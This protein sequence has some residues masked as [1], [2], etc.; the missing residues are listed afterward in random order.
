MISNPSYELALFHS[1]S[2][3]QREFCKL[4]WPFQKAWSISCFWKKTQN[5]SD[6]PYFC[7]CGSSPRS[8]SKIEC[9][10]STFIRFLFSQMCP[11][12]GQDILPVV[13]THEAE[14]HLGM[15]HSWIVEDRTIKYNPSQGFPSLGAQVAASLT[16]GSLH[17][18]RFS[19]CV[20]KIEI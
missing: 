3:G 14:M 16:A 11:S 17:S 18:L 20:R 8:C 7:F 4:R 2:Q 5:L 9:G 1:I 6:V 15:E 12:E 10:P 13:F 19:Y